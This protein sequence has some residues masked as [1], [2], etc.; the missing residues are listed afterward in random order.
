MNQHLVK[1]EHSEKKCLFNTRSC[2]V[3]TAI[4]LS[5]WYSQTLIEKK[6]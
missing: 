2:Q 1:E 3:T 5:Y 4:R 6:Q